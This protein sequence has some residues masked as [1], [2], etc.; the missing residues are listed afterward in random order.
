M[1]SVARTRADVKRDTLLPM[2]P[3]QAQAARYLILNK[4]AGA[5]VWVQGESGQPE[6]VFESSLVVYVLANG[7]PVPAWLDY[8]SEAGCCVISR[9]ADRRP[10]NWPYPAPELLLSPGAAKML[11][12]TAEE[13]VKTLDAR[14]AYHAAMN[15]RNGSLGGH[16]GRGY[17][18]KG[19][20]A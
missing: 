19:R 15:Y 3:R 9:F 16:C 18:G 11:S 14:A 5:M 1:H 6:Q 8:V 7:V 17:S 10:A 2:T 13:I 20:A 4:R 12:E